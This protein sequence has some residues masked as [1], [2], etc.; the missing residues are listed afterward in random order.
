M[1]AAG[2]KP[3]DRYL[4]FAGAMLTSCGWIDGLLY[5]I[6][7]RVLRDN[8]QRTSVTSDPDLTLHNSGLDRLESTSSKPKF[9]AVFRPT[10]WTRTQSTGSLRTS[11]F[12]VESVTSAST[13]NA[14]LPSDS[15][16]AVS[17]G[18][19]VGGGMRKKSSTGAYGISFAEFLNGD[20]VLEEEEEEEEE[21]EMEGEHQSRGHGMHDAPVS[22]GGY[23]PIK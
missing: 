22:P 3:S 15:L 1:M 12:P 21:E 4:I 9:T 20:D 18:E 16:T 5:T 13:R 11:L 14:R 8:N 10:V 6:T 17:V 2:K 19:G 23:A 7:R